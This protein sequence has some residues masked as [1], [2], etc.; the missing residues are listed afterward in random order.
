MTKISRIIAA[1]GT[2]G[3]LGAAAL[4][5]AGYAATGTKTLDT[6][7]EVN[8]NAECLI[9]NGSNPGGKALLHVD[10]SATT[11]A[12][13]DNGVGSAIG[14][15][16]NEAWTLDEEVDHTDLLLSTDNDTPGTFLFD[17]AIGFTALGSPVTASATP[18]VGD[19]STWAAN[20]WGMTYTGTDTTTDAKSWHTPPLTGSALT[21][22]S[23]NATALSSI[24]QYF[25]AKT[26]GS[27]PNGL[28]G[29]IVTYT[30]AP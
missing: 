21:I 30:L 18:V 12:A 9:G 8:V 17:G 29:A 25:G 10:L 7:V 23:G 4:P 26:D 28:Y 15:S 14:V 3:V 2:L 27:V 13:I 24:I 11:P 19:L 16:C 20:K 5:V 6:T 1:A 22:A